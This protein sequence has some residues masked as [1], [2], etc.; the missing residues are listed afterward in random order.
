MKEMKEEMRIR[1]EQLREELRWRDEN[2]AAENKKIE[3]NL[4]ALIQQR[5]KWK[6]ELA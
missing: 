6:E 4:V 1:D 2:Q 3:E 5:D